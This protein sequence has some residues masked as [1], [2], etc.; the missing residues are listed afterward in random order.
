M[1]TF[2]ALLDR[3]SGVAFIRPDRVEFH[4]EKLGGEILATISTP[5]LSVRIAGANSQHF[6][7]EDRFNPAV[8]I[9][10]QDPGIL[11]ALEANGIHTA[12]KAANYSRNRTAMRIALVASPFIFVILL[13]I[14]LPKLVGKLP[15]ELLD[16][17]VSM[18]TEMKLGQHLSKSVSGASAEKTA[19][20]VQLQELTD[21]LKSHSPRLSGQPV[22]VLVSDSQESNAYALP[23]GII[24]VNKGFLREAG[25]IEEV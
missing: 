10:V 7:L 11:R 21:H 2:A 15:P 20:Q 1:A 8:S 25:S 23:G 4:L 5:Q 22:Q 3:Q 9:C 17:V 13:L 6:Y 18:E 19:L 12:R 24:I 14:G 16:S